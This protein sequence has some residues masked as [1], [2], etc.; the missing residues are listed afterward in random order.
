MHGQ[1]PHANRTRAFRRGRIPNKPDQR[2]VAAV[3]RIK[4]RL[5]IFMTSS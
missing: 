1:K 5:V 2:A 3:A 4:S